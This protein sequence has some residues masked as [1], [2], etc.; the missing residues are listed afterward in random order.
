MDV[1]EGAYCPR[2]F[3]PLPYM[4]WAIFIGIFNFVLVWLISQTPPTWAK[5]VIL[6]LC[7]ITAGVII[8]AYL[9]R[10]HV[11]LEKHKSHPNELTISTVV[12]IQF[13][14]I[15][16]FMGLAFHFFLPHGIKWA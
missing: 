5:I 14:L 8:G 12:I 13:L 3:D 11:Y 10:M 7:A 4:G 15:A 9:Y 1:K 16:A 6:A 2:P